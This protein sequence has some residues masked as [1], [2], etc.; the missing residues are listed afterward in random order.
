MTN[1]LTNGMIRLSGEISDLRHNRAA[2]RSR[3]ALG[4]A[5]LETTVSGMIAG[6][7][8]DREEM[9]EKTRAEVAG[10]MS[11]LMG[12]RAAWSG[13]AVGRTLPLRGSR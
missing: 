3:L 8:R 12:A 9:G 7:Q 5:K 2:L 13:S 4:R 10:F 11:D 1:N 6:F